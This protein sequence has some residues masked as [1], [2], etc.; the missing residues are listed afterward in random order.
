MEIVVKKPTVHDGGNFGCKHPSIYRG[1]PGPQGP[2]GTIQIVDVVTIEPSDPAR[3]ENIGDST[4]AKLILYIPKGDAGNRGEPGPAVEITEDIIQSI[5]NELDL[6]PELIGLGNVDNTSDMDKPVSA[7]QAEAIANAKKAG[8]DAQGAVDAHIADTENPHGMTREQ[9]GA[10]P[11]GYGVGGN[12]YVLSDF[13]Q[14]LTLNKSGKYFVNGGSAIVVN[15]YNISYAYVDVI[16]VADGWSEQVM[17]IYNT[18]YKLRRKVY[19]NRGEASEW[20]WENPPMASGVE[21]RTTERSG[22]KAVYTMLINCG[23]CNNA[24]KITT[25]VNHVERYA[26]WMGNGIALPYADAGDWFCHVS[27]NTGYVE[28]WMNGFTS[29]QVYVQLWYSKD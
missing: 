22:G 5:V 29:Q 20:E 27:A 26:A 1:K 17:N 24:S 18:N 16:S 9:I 13:D 23:V 21:Y 19:G 11:D 14:L 6:T 8:T 25:G 10:A 4:N 2:A 12:P 15:G 7:A 3:V 28:V